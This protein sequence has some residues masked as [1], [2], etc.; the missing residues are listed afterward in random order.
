MINCKAQHWNLELHELKIS[1][2]GLKS[3]FW[4]YY[5]EE[6]IVLIKT[7]LP[8]FRCLFMVICKKKEGKVSS[9]IMEEILSSAVSSS[10]FLIRVPVFWFLFASSTTYSYIKSCLSFG[11]DVWNC[12]WWLTS[13][14]TLENRT[15]ATYR[16]LLCSLGNLLP[17]KKFC[18]GILPDERRIFYSMLPI[19]DI[20]FTTTMGDKIFCTCYSQY[21][22][23]MSQNDA[24]L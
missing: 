16:I 20:F 8:V 19:P 21:N 5:Q 3:D 6:M 18:W 12:S 22:L 11:N 17:P 15:K 10:V 9:A 7:G 23:F 13:A 2:R 24:D 14:G 4:G 1:P